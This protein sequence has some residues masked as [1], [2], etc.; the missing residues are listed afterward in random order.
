MRFAFSVLSLLISHLCW[1]QNT[2]GLPDIV[3]Y[4]KHT[5]H[6]GAQNRMICQDKRGNMYFANNEG[7]L[8][9]N[10]INW[11]LYPLPN[12][13]IV[14]CLEFGPDNRLYVGGQDEFGYFSAAGNGQLTFHSLK[15]VLPAE[16]RSFAD[17]W[18]I[19]FYAGSIFFHTSNRLYQITGNSSSSYPSIHWRYLTKWN[20][21]LLAQEFEKGLMEFRNGSWI[22]VLSRNDLPAEAMISSLT[23]IG[24][25]TALV[26][27]IKHGFYLFA[28]TEIRKLDGPTFNEIALSYPSS[29]LMVNDKHIAISTTQSGCFI[30]DKKGNLIQKF[31]INE[32][33]QNNNIMGVF[34]D[35]EKNLWL[36]MDNGIDFIAYNNAIKH[37]FPDYQNEGAGYA[38]G[39]TNGTL[40]LG[41]CNGLYCTELPDNKDISYNKTVFRAVNNTRGQ[42]WNLSEV[43]GKLLLGHHDGAFEI[44]G[45]EARLIDKTSGFWT[46]L[47]YSNVLPSSTMVAG[48]YHGLNFYDYASGKFSSQKLSAQFESSRFVCIANDN[49][50]VAHPYKGIFR[51][52]IKNGQYDIRQMTAKEG[53]PSANGNYIFYIKNRV[54]ATTE[55]GV[56]EYDESSKKFSP[57]D[58]YNRIFGNKKIRYLKE[59]HAGNVW[60][61]FDKTMG[62]V[63]FSS[64]NAQII[65]LPELTNKFVSGFEY[66]YPINSNNILI[67][68]EKGFYHINYEQYKKIKYPLSIEIAS[69]KALNGRDS[70]L[71]G[72][73]TGEV[74]SDALL[75]N[76]AKS[77]VSHDWNSFHFDF[78][79]PVYAQQANLEYSYIL[80]GFDEK[81]SEFSRKTEKEYT[82]VP[83]GKYRFRVKARN[84]LGNE[85]KEAVYEFT[86][87]PPWY[88]TYWAYAVYVLL[89][90]MGAGLLYR[91]QKKKFRIQQEKHETEQK[92]LQYLHQLE[93]DKAEKEL[94][95][96]R[97][98]KLEVEIQAKNSE[99]ASV[100]MHL[101]QK[102]D[103]L[104][105]I[106]DQMV[107]M[108]KTAETDEETDDI[109]KILKV[110]N[111]EDRV[112]KQWEQFAKHFDTMHGDFLSLLKSKYPKLSH[113]ELR[114][115][116]YL[117][118][119][120][121]TKEIAQ[122]MNISVRGVEISRYRLRK[123]LQIPTEMNLFEF[124][125]AL[126]NE[127]PQ[128]NNQA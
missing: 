77:A 1:G 121:S 101:V 28:G 112:D 108:K 65:Y 125:L 18:T 22:P 40:Y 80:D 82:N 95:Q 106:K 50:W 71:Y 119:N 10:G 61:V 128:I 89:F 57:S 31:S 51:V 81:W 37:I 126:E 39:I 102:G 45:N 105:K 114:L 120:L 3:N 123:K 90:V 13:S 66:V 76:L 30:I 24:K 35:K 100:A 93:M 4:G 115:S 92:K 83:A 116:A 111:A 85:S 74:N 118:M 12:N 87:L 60:F 59:D 32:G 9:F 11:R 38:A 36:G 48:T 110:I 75:S 21:R 19:S 99:L 15:S 14:R 16:Y 88:Q 52:N 124:L 25:D 86:V 20:G 33:L 97:N 68:G 43:N 107:K 53:I 84:N 58:A 109:K 79:S 72:G 70:V 5:Y 29:A 96:L 63:D 67:G 23:T 56:F 64:G 91:Y 54:L 94:V 2:I 69:V 49:I 104:G 47:P 78:A 98:E 34:L 122:L 113:N 26:T 73:Y 62:V 117:R 7:V 44:D 103:L 6:A 41:T 17:V 42:V 127:K 8:V 46:F 27:T 55:Q